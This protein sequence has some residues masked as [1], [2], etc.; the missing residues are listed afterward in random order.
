VAR[1]AFRGLAAVRRVRGTPLD[2]FGRE[3]H[4]REERALIE[5][6]EAL[7]LRALDGPHEEAVAVAQSIQQVRGYEDIKSR[8]I[9]EWREQVM[10]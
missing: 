3:R 6:Y 5:E 2:L 1:P 8:A 9:A 7:V 4:R 10:S